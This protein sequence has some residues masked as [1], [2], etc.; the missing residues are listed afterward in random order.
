MDNRLP[1]KIAVFA[2]AADNDRPFTRKDV[3]DGLR[4][5]YE[6]ERQFTEE[7]IENYLRQYLGTCML[8]ADTVE[9]TSDKQDVLV[10]YRLT[11]FGRDRKKHIPAKL[12]YN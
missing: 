12:T 3:M 10:V 5:A 9:F 11:D 6:N 4:A 2:W 1:L 7:R 8:E